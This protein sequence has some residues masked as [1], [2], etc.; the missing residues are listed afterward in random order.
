MIEQR[1]GEEASIFEEVG[2]SPAR[3]QLRPSPQ[4]AA[5]CRSP[6]SS[7]GL[8]ITKTHCLSHAYAASEQL[9]DCPVTE[10]MHI[11]ILDTGLLPIRRTK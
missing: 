1:G 2:P 9:G 3:R 6:G 11:D 10:G 7:D 4:P 8:M 5:C